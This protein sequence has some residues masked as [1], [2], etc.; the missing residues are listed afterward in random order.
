[1]IKKI[2]SCVKFSQFLEELQNL[3]VCFLPFLLMFSYEI[4]SKSLELR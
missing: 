3:L 2:L 1:M 4:L